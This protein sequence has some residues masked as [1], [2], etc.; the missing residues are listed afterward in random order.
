ML[1]WF[2]LTGSHAIFNGSFFLILQELKD[3]TVWLQKL[4]AEQQLELQKANRELSE[5]RS[6]HSADISSDVA[7]ARKTTAFD[8]RIDYIYS[9]D[10]SDRSMQNLIQKAAS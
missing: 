6:L 5:L 7:A 8:K 9:Q 3:E 1:S 2:I 4:L 10:I